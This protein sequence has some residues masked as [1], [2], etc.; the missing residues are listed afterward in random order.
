[1]IQLYLAG[2]GED[3]EEKIKYQ[4]VQQKGRFK[5]TSENVDLE[6]ATPENLTAT[7][8]LP[9]DPTPANHSSQSIFPV[10]Q[11]ALQATIIGRE[12]IL[13]AMRQ[14]TDST[15][16]ILSNSAGVEKSLLEAALDREKDLHREVAD[17]RWR[18]ER[19]QEELQKYKTENKSPK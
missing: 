4:V 7:Q 6:K 17:L 5:V 18:L 14:V 15:G 3:C 11:N 10:L 1:M 12:S 16:C 9:L 2:S 13:S 8:P 19:S